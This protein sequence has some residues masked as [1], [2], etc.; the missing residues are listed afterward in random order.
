M[1]SDIEIILERSGINL[2]NNEIYNL[3]FEMNMNEAGIEL[4]AN[5][6]WNALQLIMK[7]ATGNRTKDN[8]YVIQTKT[9]IEV[10]INGQ[11][12]FY[13]ICVLTG[14]YDTQLTPTSLKAQIKTGLKHFSA[15]FSNIKKMK[16]KNYRPNITT[17]SP[18]GAFI[19]ATKEL[20]N[21][22]HD[23]NKRNNPNIC[24]PIKN[25]AGLVDRYEIT[26]PIT[27]NNNYMIF[28]IIIRIPLKRN[29]IAFIHTMFRDKKEEK[30]Q[31][32]NKKYP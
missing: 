12:K 1:L 24:K 5:N 27:Y 4:A 19:E 15:H 23:S 28:K 31:Q 3:L 6:I 11:S 2:S 25:K 22:L 20:N 10:K 9:N 21:V 13:P 17:K 29:E 8:K 16:N 14:D 18:F 30:K 7:K 32:H 26:I